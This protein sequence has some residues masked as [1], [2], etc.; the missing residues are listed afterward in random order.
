MR[1]YVMSD[2]HP[3]VLLVEDCPVTA[4]L[5][6][7]SVMND[8]PACRVLWARTVE[9][10]SVRAAALPVELFIVDI[11]LP[12]GSGLD[13]LWNMSINNPLARAIVM[14]ATPRPEHQ[15]S[16][17][18]LGV[19]HFLEKPVKIPALLAMVRAALASQNLTEVQ[20]EFRATLKNVT[21][22]DIL[23]LKCLSSATTVVE[24]HSQAQ[25]G[26]VRIETGEIVDAGVGGLQGL[27]ALFQIVSWKR[28]N[29]SERPASGKLQRTIHGSCESLLIAAA[30]RRDEVQPAL[31]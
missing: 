8:M 18:A 19:L 12:D 9:E 17:A 16:S 29:V 11:G 28:G 4:L 15:M 24:F 5:I 13:F 26:W 30:Q 14:T 10:A 27:D 21:P 23:Q 7:R 20:E 3:I 31:A 6:E 2:D 1:Q 22:G 25:V